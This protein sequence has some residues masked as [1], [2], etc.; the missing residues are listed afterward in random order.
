M[1]LLN[2][3]P[4][5]PSAPGGGDAAQ[6]KVPDAPDGCQAG[7]RPGA[8]GGQRAGGG[9]PALAGSV[10]L[11]LPLT[12]WLGWSQTP[13]QVPGFGPVDAQDSRTLAAMLARNSGTKWCLTLTNQRVTR[14]PTAV[15]LAARAS[16]PG[17]T[18][19][20]DSEPPRGKGP[21]GGSGPPGGSDPPEGSDPPGG[22]RPPGGEGPP[23]GSDPPRGY[24]L[25]RDSRP[26]DRGQSG[27][28]ALGAWLSGMTVHS[29]TGPCDH[30]QATPGYRP[31]RLLR[32]LARI[33]HQSCTRPGC[34]RPAG[35]CDLDHTVP[36]DQGGL[37]CLCPPASHNHTPFALALGAHCPRCG[38]PLVTDTF[39]RRQRAGGEHDPVD[40]V[41]AAE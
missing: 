27:T 1:I 2:G 26:Q 40:R 39:C 22:N 14:L 25:A 36:Y 20:R 5:I 9:P 28:D 8:G 21:T 7:G 31:S 18:G 30:A 41:G 13:G 4:V 38:W 15:L 29:L 23:G 17:S 34:R 37:T 3:Q 16:R 24:R 33:R 6:E 10:N 19:R 35:Q 11:I 12:T 32:H